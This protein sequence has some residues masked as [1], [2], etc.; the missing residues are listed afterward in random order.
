QRGRAPSRTLVASRAKYPGGRRCLLPPVLLS[1]SSSRV[2]PRGARWAL[3][4]G[5]GNR[6][7]RGGMTRLRL[8]L[9]TS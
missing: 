9:A 2:L 4:R 1:T 6:A 7:L 3:R 8:G 5:L